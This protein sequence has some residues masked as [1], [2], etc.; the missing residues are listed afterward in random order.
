MRYT[1]TARYRLLLPFGGLLLAGAVS[2]AADVPVTLAIRPAIVFAG[3]DVRATVRTP[4][5]PRNRELRI[6][7]EAGDYYASSD[8]QLDGTDAPATHQFTWKE[9]PSGAY[10]VEAILTREDGERQTVTQCFAVLGLDDTADTLRAPPRRS[11]P[12]APLATESRSGC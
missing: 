7:V 8:V 3:R 11:A 5:D 2:Q 1:T 9:L 6:V 10:R 12:A 4:R